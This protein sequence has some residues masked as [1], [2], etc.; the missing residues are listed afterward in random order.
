MTRP[1]FSFSARSAAR[2]S[3]V[4]GRRPRQRPLPGP[5]DTVSWTF[6]PLS[7]L[8]RT[9]GPRDHGAGG[10]AA[11]LV[12]DADREAEV[13][14]VRARGRDVEVLH[15]RDD[16]LCRAR[17]QV[18]RDAAAREQQDQQQPERA[19]ARAGDR[20]LRLAAGRRRRCSGIRARPTAGS[21][22]ARAAD[23]SS[24]GPARCPSRWRLRRPPR[25]S[26]SADPRS[27]T[28]SRTSPTR[29]RLQSHPRRSGDPPGSC[30]AP[31]SPPPRARAGCFGLSTVSGVGASE[32]A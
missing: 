8:R 12:E 23:S 2:P 11:R 3:A 29:A 27:R 5:F 13:L 16:H 31:T 18:R 9:A 30:S 22:R 19:T 14:E 7:A 20:T 24:P 25:C 15:L 26:R 1:S 32:R 21:A 4:A 6:E 28:G 10:V 17:E